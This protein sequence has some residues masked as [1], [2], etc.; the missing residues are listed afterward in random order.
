M[1]RRNSRPVTAIAATLV[2]AALWL[3]DPASAAPLSSS[4]PI[5]MPGPL[6]GLVDWLEG[7]LQRFIPPPAPPQTEPPY[8]QQE[9]M[10]SKKPIDDSGGR[11]GTI[12][13]NGG[14][15]TGIEHMVVL[16]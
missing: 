8:Q 6:T 16:L 3:G 2:L 10:D 1:P 7:L 15:T 5:Q 14:S 13:P 4:L 12:D 9:P 11:G